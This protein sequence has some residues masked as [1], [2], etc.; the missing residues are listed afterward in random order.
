MLFPGRL[1]A[2]TVKMPRPL[3]SACRAATPVAIEFLSD[4]FKSRANKTPA[5]DKVSTVEEMKAEYAGETDG[6]RPLPGKS[7][8][9]KNFPESEQTTPPHTG[10]EKCNQ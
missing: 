6:P 4:F 10:R 8:A 5:A 7:F 3:A 1:K 2:T 9:F